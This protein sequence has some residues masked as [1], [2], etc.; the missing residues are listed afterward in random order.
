[1]YTCANVNMGWLRLVGS[2][3]LQVSFA[4]Y[5]L[6]YRALLQERPIIL[7]SLLIEATPY[8][9]LHM[10]AYHELLIG[11]STHVHSTNHLLAFE[12]VYIL[13]ITYWHLHMC[14]Y[15]NSPIGVWKCVHCTNYLLAFEH[16]YTLLH[17][18][19]WHL[20]M[21]T[22][23]F[24]LVRWWVWMCV[25]E[26]LC[27]CM[28]VCVCVCVCMCVCLCERANTCACMYVFVRWCVC[29]CAPTYTCMWWY[30][31]VSFLF[32]ND[33]YTHTRML[34]AERSS[35]CGCF[36]SHLKLPTPKPQT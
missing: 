22:Y 29:E 5:S 24:W 13:E 35:K 33:T 27:V 20:H 9:H 36:K 17:I 7:R 8:C 18:T 12:Y 28:R 3:K 16:V 11:T 1:M 32:G 15:Y 34:G 6:F 25:C 4:E 31:Y 21:C 23:Q 2:L 14:T 19:Y 10:R 26:C 30:I